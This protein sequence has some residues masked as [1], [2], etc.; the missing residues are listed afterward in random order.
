MIRMKSSKTKRGEVRPQPTKDEA[1]TTR[2]RNHKQRGSH[3]GK[4]EDVTY[5][6]VLYNYDDNMIKTT[7]TRL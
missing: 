7:T 3:E 4:L 5:V 6:L 2:N 1:D